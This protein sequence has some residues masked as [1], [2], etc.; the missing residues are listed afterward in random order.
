ML[1]AP[2]HS[3]IDRL[4]GFVGESLKAIR[5]AASSP[6]SAE[7]VAICSPKHGAAATRQA[8]ARRQ[9]GRPQRSQRPHQSASS[10]ASPAS[11]SRSGDRADDGRPRR[12]LP[13]ALRRVR[14]SGVSL[15]ASSTWDG[16]GRA[17]SL[18]RPIAGPGSS[19]VPPRCPVPLPRRKRV[20]GAWRMPV[21]CAKKLGA[22]KAPAAAIFRARPGCF[23]GVARTLTAAH[24]GP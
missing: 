20:A 9:A 23:G 3:A 15:V 11:G 24:H 1:C 5:Q 6:S 7:T 22:R 4:P 16:M 10:R 12:R 14:R 19:R 13:R 2:H 17:P 8:L 18:P 21:R